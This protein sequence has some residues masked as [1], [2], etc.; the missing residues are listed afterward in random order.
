MERIIK[1]VIEI[2]EQNLR[3]PF[4]KLFEN[5]SHYFFQ[6]NGLG[7]IGNIFKWPDKWYKMPIQLTKHIYI[8]KDWISMKVMKE[9]LTEVQNILIDLSSDIK[10][11]IEVF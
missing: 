2:E 4:M 10:V 3:E 7:D 8:Y 5:K 6:H 1:M 9:H 11:R